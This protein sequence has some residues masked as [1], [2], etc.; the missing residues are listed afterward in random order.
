MVRVCRHVY[1]LHP[2]V[3][4][5]FAA[6]DRQPTAHDGQRQ[7]ATFSSILVTRFYFPPVNQIHTSVFLLPVKYLYF[8]PVHQIQVSVFLLEIFT[9]LIC[10][11]LAITNVHI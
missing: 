5:D 6:T 11:P 1:C 7:R 3:Q 8:F 9:D 10:S 2:T 4:G